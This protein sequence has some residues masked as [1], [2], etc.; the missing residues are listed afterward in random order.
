MK[1]N[2]F[3]YAAFAAFMTLFTGTAQSYVKEMD[4]WSNGHQNLFCLSDRHI[5]S[6]HNTLQRQALIQQANK[7]DGLIIVEDMLDYN[8]DKPQ[9]Q[10]FVDDWKKEASSDNNTQLLLG[11][12]D[13]LQR[14]N[15]QRD[16]VEFR[17]EKIASML[18]LSVS[19]QD[20]F[21]T[22]NKLETQLK[23]SSNKQ[24][25][26]CYQNILEK[27]DN[28]LIRSCK[29]FF[30]RFKSGQQSLKELLPAVEYDTSYDSILTL[31]KNH[32][33]MNSYEK[34]K[35]LL[36]LYDIPLIDAHIIRSIEQNKHCTNIYVCAGGAHIN[37]INK[38]LEALGY[39][40]ID[41]IKGD[42]PV[43]NEP[44]ALD[45]EKAFGQA[46]SFELAKPIAQPKA[47][48]YLLYILCVIAFALCG[49]VLILF[50]KMNLSF[51]VILAA[52]AANSASA[53]IYRMDC[54]NNGQQT[55]YTLGDFHITNNKDNQNADQQR[56]D[57]ICE[58]KKRNAV[59]L[60]EDIHP[61]TQALMNNPIG[62]DTNKNYYYNADVINELKNDS[63][64][65]PIFGL[66]PCC[67]DAHTP[68]V[69]IEFR[70]SN[71]AS[72]HGKAVSAKDSFAVSQNIRNEICT[73]NDGEVLN[74]YYAKIIG[75]YDRCIQD[76]ASFFDQIKNCGSTNIKELMPQLKNNR[77]T[78]AVLRYLGWSNP[79]INDSTADEKNDYAIN[80]YD[81][82]LVDMK[83]L[84]EIH[85]HTSQPIF[86]CAGALH[87]R[88]IAP[89]LE[90]LGY[91]KLATHGQKDAFESGKFE[92]DTL[93]VA[94]T[95]KQLDEKVPAGIP[96]HNDR[97]NGA[98]VWLLLVFASILFILHRNRKQKRYIISGIQ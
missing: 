85:Q 46:K 25:S 57:I 43:A 33:T 98:I 1:K 21:N 49:L 53:H 41:Y 97:M 82:N 42:Q 50:K 92:P 18:G 89:V 51:L 22:F 36:L 37:N 31:V 61:N 65:P 48:K 59:I 81:L 6:E 70:H 38:H 66:V 23:N 79:T 47:D 13:H 54:W 52:L 60:V 80:F 17:Q 93:D 9:V 86:V 24:F 8:G 15:I 56:I 95:F 28:N 26:A 68:A 67:H 19:S 32:T 74:N 90:K 16:N 45:L 63:V 58:A 27:R 75:E 20:V 73:Y 64:T 35:T 78:D 7:D 88:G 72:G 69:N 3:L 30:D 77:G 29:K 12:S 62:Y 39:K 83:I 11:L 2:T 84:H 96:V 34:K 55:I 10:S 14:N 94:Q 40:Y 71:N 44:A 87:I 91:K 5:K 76:G 4:V